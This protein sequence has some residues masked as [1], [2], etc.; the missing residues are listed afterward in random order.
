MQLVL[1]TGAW[2]LN[3][4]RDILHGLWCVTWS[5]PRKCVY[6]PSACEI[7]QFVF[8]LLIVFI[9]CAVRRRLVWLH[10]SWTF[11]NIFWSKIFPKM[12]PMHLTKWVFCSCLEKEKK[13]KKLV[14][15]SQFHLFCD[16]RD[17]VSFLKYLLS[18]VLLIP[19]AAYCYCYQSFPA[20]CPVNVLDCQ[21]ACWWEH[22]I[23]HCA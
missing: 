12:F 3:P 23:Y 7:W 6:F 14:S 8:L 15:L 11:K 2:T 9:H 13:K 22:A 10:F 16:F 18:G 4:D 21:M 1:H 17:A 20:T 5:W 19:G